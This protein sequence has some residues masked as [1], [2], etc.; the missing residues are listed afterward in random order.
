M[1]DAYYKS[2][3]QRRELNQR[4]LKNRGEDV[5]LWQDYVDIQKTL[6]QHAMAYGSL[7][8]KRLTQ[9]LCSTLP[10]EIRNMIY[11]EILSLEEVANEVAT[12][13][14]CVVE[15]YSHSPKT[16]RLSF[17][18]RM[19]HFPEQYATWGFFCDRFRREFVMNY[20]FRTEF[21]LDRWYDLHYFLFT[22][23]FKTGC[24]PLTL[25][26]KLTLLVDAGGL[27]SIPKTNKGLQ[28]FRHGGTRKGF[29]LMLDCSAVIRTERMGVIKD[30]LR[31]VVH[32]L[33]E[34]DISVEY[35]YDGD[36][37]EI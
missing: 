12:S 18:D 17:E 7:R 27:T 4:G 29:E 15:P 11:D 14:K 6:Q 33:E 5:D 8:S 26:P 13:R 24:K 9:K 21:Q 2:L 28:L 1:S 10:S 23:V 32:E 19:S 35:T 25:I 31:G 20:Y 34:E 16:Y 22:D 3:R 37:M 30:G 36:K